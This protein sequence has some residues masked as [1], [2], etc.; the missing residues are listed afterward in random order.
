MEHA[1]QKMRY[2]FWSVL[3]LTIAALFLLILFFV[4]P[5]VGRYADSLY[6]A[7]NFSV[8]AEG[9]T[10]ITPDIVIGSFSVVSRGINPETLTKTNTDKMNAVVTFVKSQ[11]IE[12]KDIKT[13]QYSLN[14]EY[15]YDQQIQRSF[16]TGYT[17][18]QTIEVKM[19][20][21]EKAPK[22][23]GGLTPLGV[24]QIGSLQYTVEDQD[25]YLGEARRDAIEKA[26]EKAAQLAK[27][28]GVKLG[29]LMSV[30][31]W[32]SPIYPTPLY[33]DGRGGMAMEKSVSMPSLE[34]GQ[35]ELKVSVSL[36]YAID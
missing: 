30:N 16:I 23:L 8:S 29:R 17:L 35:T 11:G 31:E 13:T 18:T 21:L 19:R 32:T 25:K 24:N 5:A 14:P 26:Q 12:D 15:Q 36:T 34:P 7:R 28:S 22:I 10:K 4:M 2:Y 6:S 1:L 9:S 20:D 3:T 33:A 27:E